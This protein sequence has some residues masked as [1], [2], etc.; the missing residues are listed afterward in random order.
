MGPFQGELFCLGRRL[1]KSFDFRSA[2]EKRVTTG[3][4]MFPL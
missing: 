3:E 4:W 2:L 1:E